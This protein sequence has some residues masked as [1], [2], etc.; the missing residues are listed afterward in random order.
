MDEKNKVDFS[1]Y[2]KT[3]ALQASIALG[4][5]DNPLTKSVQ[6]NIPQ[7]R[8]IIDTLIMLKEKTQGNLNDEESSLLDKLIYELGNQYAHKSENSS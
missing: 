8:I 5:I 2:I 7:A 4:V 1:F 3:L 6:Q